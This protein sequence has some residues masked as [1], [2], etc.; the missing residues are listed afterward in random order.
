MYTRMLKKEENKTFACG[1]NFALLFHN[2]KQNLFLLKSFQK[3]LF[4]FHVVSGSVCL[5]STLVVVRRVTAVVSGLANSDTETRMRFLS[6]VDEIEILSEER[7][8]LVCVGVI[9]QNRK[10]ITNYICIM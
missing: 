6:M 1:A 5:A 7:F 3:T 2:I 4:P 10:F 8:L 9:L